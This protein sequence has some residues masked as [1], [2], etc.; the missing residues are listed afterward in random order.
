MTL[1]R[2]PVTE[3]WANQDL[4]TNDGIPFNEFAT[5]GDRIID[6]HPDHIVYDVAL[7]PKRKAS[8]VAKFRA[9]RKE[10][11]EESF[12]VASTSPDQI[13]LV[14]DASK[15][16]LPLQAVAAWHAWR[17]GGD[18]HKEWH[19]GRLGTS[20]YVELLALSEAVAWTG[21]LLFQLSEVHIYSDLLKAI[22]WLFDALNYSSMECFLAALWAI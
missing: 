7:P 1:I 22:H 5:P 13:A 8:E 19:A 17:F 2:S 4:C 16:P 10:A 6:R 20:N 15:P 12:A 11:L 21:N 3:T 14:C 9:A 18:V